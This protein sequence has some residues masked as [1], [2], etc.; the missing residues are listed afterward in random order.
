MPVDTI[1]GVSVALVSPSAH[2][3]ASR[4]NLEWDCRTCGREYGRS[5]M[6]MTALRLQV[7]HC[8]YA[9][10]AALMAEKG[11]HFSGC[12]FCPASAR[13]A[14][15]SVMLRCCTLGC[16]RTQDG[17]GGGLEVGTV[18]RVASFWNGTSSAATWPEQRTDLIHNY[19]WTASRVRRVIRGGSVK[20]RNWR[21]T[22]LG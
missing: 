2:R 12:C 15:D 13:C 8:S 4:G 22:Q 9:S 14:T 5:V 17:V 16:S 18:N 1:S 3:Q 21:L 6:V 20:C 19:N 7:C 11:T 10:C